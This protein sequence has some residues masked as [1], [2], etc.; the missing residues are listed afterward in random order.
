VPVNEL[1]KMPI[2][3]HLQFAI[4]D[5]YIHNTSKL[6][7]ACISQDKMQRKQCRKKDR[8]EDKLMTTADY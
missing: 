3:W 5:L 4:I 1:D 7:L 8:V 6:K 2:N